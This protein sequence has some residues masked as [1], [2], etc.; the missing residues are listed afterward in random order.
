M[1]KINFANIQSALGKAKEAA[2]PLQNKGHTENVP[3]DFIVLADK[4]IYNESDNDESIKELADN[5]E[6]CGLLHP[7]TV[8]KIGAEKYQ[9]ISGERRF[10]AITEYLHWKSVPCMVFEDLSSEAAQL[11]LC[12]ANLAVREY[13]TSQKYKFYLE[14]KALLEKM[15]ASG[16]YKGGLQKGI[17]EIL[18]VTKRQV[19]RY[20]SIEKLPVEIQND[21]L[22]GKITLNQA[23]EYSPTSPPHISETEDTLKKISEMLSGL[24]DEE[25]AAVLS[26]FL[27]TGTQKDDIGHLSEQTND[28][29]ASKNED[30]GSQNDDIGHHFEQTNDVSV[31]KNEDTDSKN[32]DIG[33]HFEQ[34]NDVSAS[35]NEDTVS[36]NDDI[37]HHFEQTNDV[38]A[39]KNEDTDSKNDDIGHHFEAG[40]NIT[41]S[42]DNTDSNISPELPDIQM[43]SRSPSTKSKSKENGSVLIFKD[44]MFIPNKIQV[45]EEHE[46]YTVFKVFAVKQ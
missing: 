3:V 36:Q 11:K 24:S 33:H 45:I 32:D 25:R 41:N 22:E 17:A 29:F 39:S 37:G 4:N 23:L 9:I 30:T 26:D 18:N 14:V 1:G 28:V 46:S 5:I 15:K 10:R 44:G 43:Q 12:M 42:I 27:G 8:N 7:I 21:V 20:S 13:T 6:A 40:S 2:A 35:K 34:T 31:S 38:S 16:E 19:A